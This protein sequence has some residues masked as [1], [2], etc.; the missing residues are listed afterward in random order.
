V[1]ELS[2]RL[3]AVALCALVAHAVL[4]RSVW[5]QDG[6]HGYFGWY[7][8]VVGAL[9]IG[10]LV[11]FPLALAASALAETERPRWVS[12]LLP[13]RRPGS[14]AREVARLGG[15]AA[16]FLV[17]QETLEHVLQGGAVSPLATFGPSSWLVLAVVLT[18]TAAGVVAVQRT[19]AAL[20]ERTRLDVEAAPAELPSW[21]ATTARLARLRPLA[22]HAGLRAPPFPR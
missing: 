3:V 11:F 10:A 8:F 15:L 7:A 9:S 6:A 20:V 5:P 22:L 2:R 12:A 19:M 21:A 18:I 13:E 17:L 4:Y 16:G 14:P 1:S